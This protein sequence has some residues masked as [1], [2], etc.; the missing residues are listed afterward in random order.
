[1]SVP[2]EGYVLHT[3]G[4][5]RFVRHALASV[6]SLRRYDR[7]RPVALFC[8]QS[9]L[10]LLKRAGLDH[11]F[12]DIFILPKENRSIVGF[13][14]HLDKFMVYDRS[15]FLDSDM[16]WCKNPDPLWAQLSAFSFTA[17]GLERADFFFGGPKGLAVLGDI[18]LDKRRATMKRFGLTGLPR[19]Q[20][21]MIYCQDREY[22]QIVSETA[23]YF[24]AQHAETHFRSRLKEGRNEESCE[25]SLAMAMSRLRLPVFPW[26]QGLNSPQLDFVEG[27]TNYDP[28]FE[29][30]TS[31]YY[32]DRL[33]Y[34]LRGLRNKALRDVLIRVL[35][36][37]PGKGDYYD[38]TPYVL[39]FGWLHHKQPFY[40]FASRVWEELAVEQPIAVPVNGHAIFTNGMVNPATV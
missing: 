6:V 4:P 2:I 22:A 5:D 38:V 13:K 15:L 32:A 34:S 9:H 31:R 7:K 24:L 1:M 8:P 25:W 30:V 3:Y 20:A 21:G 39:H 36:S 11:H 28:N 27:L 17:T 19:V 14:H 37:L 23:A 33:V 35:S 40:D 16:I 26:L 10:S 12:Q 29:E 18:L